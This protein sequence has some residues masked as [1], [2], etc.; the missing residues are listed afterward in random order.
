MGNS[1]SMFGHGLRFP[2]LPFSDDM[3]S[4]LIPGLNSVNSPED[5]LSGQIPPTLT[6]LLH[7]PTHFLRL[8][9]HGIAFLRRDRSDFG[10][11]VLWSGLVTSVALIAWSHNSQEDEDEDEDGG[12][13]VAPPEFDAVVLGSTRR[14][15]DV[16][17]KANGSEIA[18]ESDV[19]YAEELQMQE[20]M[21]ASLLPSRISNNAMSPAIQTSPTS[22]AE[23]S[24]FSC[25]ICFEEIESWRKFRN[26]TCSHSFCYDCT[27]KHITAKIQDN[28]KII[29]CP[30]VDCR[31]PLDFNTCRQIIPNDILVKWDESLCKSLIP[32]SQTVYCPFMDCLAMLVNDSGEVIKKIEC[33]ACWRS[34]CARCGVPWHLEFTCEEFERLNAKKKKGKDDDGLVKELAK[35]KSWRKCPNC[36]IYVEKTEGCLHITCRCGYEFCYRCGSKWGKYHGGC[37]LQA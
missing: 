16:L 35:K 24:Q 22:N 6:T 31:A 5:E 14:F 36:K 9:T 27:S 23:P 11:F 12:D 20:V 3:F 30:E 33:P 26:Q 15:E 2:S 7:L 29:L 32:E 28:V 34:I 4:G 17:Y 1:V 21:L 8:F 19:L 13:T 37:S 18:S 10:T 25:G